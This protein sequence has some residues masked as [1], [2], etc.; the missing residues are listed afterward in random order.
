MRKFSL[1]KNIVPIELEGADGKPQTLEIREM[2]AASRDKYLEQLSDRM[3][4][5]VTGKP[6]GIKKFEGMHAA[7]LSLCLYREG[8]LVKKE[9]IQLWP[10][11]M[12][13]ELFNEAQN[14]NRLNDDVG[15]VQEEIKNA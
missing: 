5:D 3:R 1:K 14:T 13:T 12:V 4:F 7:L 6:A 2:D 9:E 10:A 15:E 8:I 11:S